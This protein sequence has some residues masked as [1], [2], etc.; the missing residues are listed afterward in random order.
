MWISRKPLWD[1]CGILV[2]FLQDPCRKFVCE[3]RTSGHPECVRNVSRMCPEFVW[4]SGIRPE[5]V[6]NVSGMCPECVWNV[7]G[8]CPKFV[9]TS[10]FCLEYVS[11]NCLKIIVCY[12]LGICFGVYLAYICRISGV[13]LAYI[14]RTS[15]VYL[16][17][18]WRIFGVYL[19]YI[20]RISGVYFAYIWRIFAIYQIGRAH[21]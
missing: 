6:R 17:Y 1:S 15:G 14:W 9:R 5:C 10:G 4:T 12:F 19:A 8:R 18:I 20:C 11:G 3:F 16:A 13:Y 21:V 2:G 7:S